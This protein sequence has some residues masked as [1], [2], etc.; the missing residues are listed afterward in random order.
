MT[1]TASRISE[2]CLRDGRYPASRRRPEAAS[3]ATCP[4]ASLRLSLLTRGTRGRSPR[5]VCRCS[6]CL[7]SGLGG[8]HHP[9]PAQRHI[10]CSS[11]PGPRF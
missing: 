3:K 5:A 7:R 11:E 8:V 2:A 10:R 4:S 9:A 1:Q 6:S